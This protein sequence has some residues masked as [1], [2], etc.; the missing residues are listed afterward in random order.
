[1]DY[2]VTF[3]TEVGKKGNYHVRLW[4]LALTLTLNPNTLG[5]MASTSMGFWHSTPPTQTRM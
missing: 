5:S 4:L 3:E 1:M 2:W